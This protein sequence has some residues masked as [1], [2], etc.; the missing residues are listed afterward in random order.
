MALP[1]INALL[2]ARERAVFA[3]AFFDSLEMTKGVL[4]P[5]V[6]KV[7]KHRGN[8]LDRALKGRVVRGPSG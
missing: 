1:N 6:A 5:T 4:K 2:K 8:H 7:Q 3:R